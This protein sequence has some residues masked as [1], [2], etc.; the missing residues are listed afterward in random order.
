MY[1]L[2]I[3]TGGT[4]TDFTAADDSGLIVKAKVPSSRDVTAFM[5]QGLEAL[6]RSVGSTAVEFVRSIRLLVHATTVPLNTLLQGRGPAVGLICTE[7]FR[8]TRWRFARA[9]ATT[10]TTSRIRLG[11]RRD[12]Q[13]QHHPGVVGGENEGHLHGHVHADVL[14]GDVQHVADYPKL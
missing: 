7:G 11:D 4:F 8:A 14:G 10:G 9:T 13:G 12:E 2:S 3:D 1:L 6:S 5:T